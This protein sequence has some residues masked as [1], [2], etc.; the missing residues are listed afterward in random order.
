ML[1]SVFS[2]SLLSR[3]GRRPESRL[4]RNGSATT[5]RL[6]I[7][8]GNLLRRKPSRTKKPRSFLRRL[9][10]T[11]V[12]VRPFT[13]DLNERLACI[14][15]SCKLA[16]ADTNSCVCAQITETGETGGQVRNRDRFRKILCLC[17]YCERNTENRIAKYLLLEHNYL[18]F[19]KIKKI[20]T[21]KLKNYLRAT[22]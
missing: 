9:C 20:A 5:K 15:T 19:I 7:S 21:K 22:E 11:V 8:S 4:S 10:S 16:T 13:C 6:A 2:S 17:I 18:S 12:A 3:P 1:S 14:Q